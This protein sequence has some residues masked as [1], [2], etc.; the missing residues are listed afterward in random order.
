MLIHSYQSDSYI[1][2]L[3]CQYKIHL[4]LISLSALRSYVFILILSLAL[5]TKHSREPVDVF[6]I[7]AHV[8]PNLF[9][10]YALY[11]GKCWSLVWSV[12]GSLFH[13]PLVAK[14]MRWGRGWNGEGGAPGWTWVDGRTY[15]IYRR[16][17]VGGGQP[18]IHGKRHTH[19][20]RHHHHGKV[21]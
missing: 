5:L 17:P 13:F 15:L 10:K 16:C 6:S 1:P 21:F 19:T 9:I 7:T 4:R 18:I 12:P 2:F 11:L 20:N 8:F 14:K 3:V